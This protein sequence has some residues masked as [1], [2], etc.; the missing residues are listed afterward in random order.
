MSRR[1]F[2]SQKALQDHAEK[3]ARSAYW[4][5]CPPSTA[6]LARSIRDRGCAHVPWSVAAGAA[7]PTAVLKALTVADQA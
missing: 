5:D 7:D 1:E 3:T 4:K 2:T 6:A